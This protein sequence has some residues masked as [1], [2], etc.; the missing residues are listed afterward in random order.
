MKLR[1][2]V[3]GKLTLAGELAVVLAAGLVAADHAGDLLSVVILQAGALVVRAL[4]AG[5]AVRR[6]GGS[7]G[8]GA[9]APQHRGVR[10]VQPCS[11]PSAGRTTQPK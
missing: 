9:A 8:G 7:E 11:Q 10:P 5:V 3:D 6:K 4:L 1:H 2:G